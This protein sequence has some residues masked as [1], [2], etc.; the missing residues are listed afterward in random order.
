M[1][2]RTQLSDEY[3]KCSVVQFGGVYITSIYLYIPSMYLKHMC[4]YTVE[5]SDEYVKRSGVLQ[6][7]AVCIVCC[8]ALKCA[9]CVA[10]R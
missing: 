7:I 10:V 4:T 5:L 9:W 1:C 3:V 6:C 2:L 8:S